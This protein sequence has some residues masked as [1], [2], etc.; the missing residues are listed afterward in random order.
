LAILGLL[1]LAMYSNRSE[2]GTWVSC[3]TFIG[4]TA[5]P[6]IKIDRFAI[7]PKIL[8]ITRGEIFKLAD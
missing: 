3:D 4:C 8:Y 5:S 7:S 2:M 1:L 6:E